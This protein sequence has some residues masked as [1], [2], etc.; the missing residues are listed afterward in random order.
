MVGGGP[1]GLETARVAAIRGHHVVL[2]ER[3]DELGGLAAV[4]RPEPALVEW[5]AA[6]VGRLGVDV[7]TGSDG[8]CRPATSSSCSAR[9]RS[10]GVREYEIADGAVVVDVAD[11][12][13]G[14]AALPD[15]G[16]VVVFD[17]IG[18]PIGVAMAEELGGRAVLVT[19]DNIAGNEL[20]RTGDLAPAN[21]RLAQAG[22]RI[23]RR[24]VLRAVAAGAVALR[25]RF[26]A[27]SA[28]CRAPPS[29]TA[30]SACPTE[31]LAGVAAQAGDCVAPRTVHEAV[32]E[33]PARR[34][35]ARSPTPTRRLVPLGG[36]EERRS[37]AR[38][39]RA[40]WRPHMPCTP[41]PGGVE[42]EQR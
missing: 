6:E 31:P 28:S 22:V 8:S 36:S 23:E 15:T 12:R 21:V 27:S 39:R 35:R 1:A 26:R 42:A 24:S 34:R 37:S 5:L 4:G 11:L 13:H 30:A 2:V 7:R 9:G 25:D 17:P 38:A 16:D 3:A 32:L 33:A 29:S 18:G 14:V 41:A 19:Q 10:P 20:A 40:A